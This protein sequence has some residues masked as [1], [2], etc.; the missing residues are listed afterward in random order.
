MVT[1]RSTT[2]LAVLILTARVYA[3]VQPGD[4]ITADNVDKVRDLISP[5]LEWCIKRGFPITIG[6]PKHVEWPRA[7]REATEKYASQVKLSPDG[8]DL[9]DYVAGLPF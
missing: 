9:R 3:D 7:Y 5:G 6:E 4:R 1:M 2:L 8:L